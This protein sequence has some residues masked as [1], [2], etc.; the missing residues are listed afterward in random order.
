MEQSKGSSWGLL[1]FVDVGC[2]WT[3]SPAVRSRRLLA[4]SPRV[5]TWTSGAPPRECRALQASSGAPPRHQHVPRPPS[6]ACAERQCVR[7]PHTSRAGVWGSELSAG[8]VDVGGAAAGA[9][10]R[11]GR[12]RAACECRSLGQRPP[13]RWVAPV[14]RCTVPPGAPRGANELRGRECRL[15]SV[16]LSLSHA[17]VA[18]ESE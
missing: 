6:P 7:L 13:M 15:V 4:S 14:R 11:P 16:G 3:A 10:G 12:G 1:L 5:G 2:W 18:R 8:T 17:R 9:C